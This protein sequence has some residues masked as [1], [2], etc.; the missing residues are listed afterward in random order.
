MQNVI[1]IL[2]DHAHFGGGIL[3]YFKRSFGVLLLDQVRQELALKGGYI[4]L[5][6]RTN[7]RGIFI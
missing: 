3:N 4:L 6:Q 1:L 5:L 7:I 2:G